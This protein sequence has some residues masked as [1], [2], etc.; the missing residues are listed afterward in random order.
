MT[1]VQNSCTQ[2]PPSPE[3]AT[4]SMH[5]AAF[6]DALVGLVDPR[7][8][9]LNKRCT[10]ISES[11]TNPSR[12]LAHF[13]DGTTHETD[14]VLG[15]DDIKSAVRHFVVARRTAK[16]LAISNAIACRSSIPYAQLDAAGCKAKLTHHSACFLGPG[17]VS[18]RCLKIAALSA[19][20]DVPIGSQNLPEGTPRVDQVSREDIQKAFDGW[21]VDVATLLRFTPEKTVPWSVYVVCPHLR[22]TARGMRLFCETQYAHG[23]LPHLGAGAGQGLEDALLLV[24]LLSHTETQT[25]NLQVRRSAC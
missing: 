17:K 25:E 3:D 12:L 16:N 21:G 9:R 5:R 18:G 6:L 24:R 1:H 23:T 15:A 22:D 20:Y 13:T 14:V 7:S 4:I 8:T 10:S 11:P 19:R 2:H